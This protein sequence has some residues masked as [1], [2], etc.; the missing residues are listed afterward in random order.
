MKNEDVILFFCIGVVVVCVLSVFVFAGFQKE[1][2]QDVVKVFTYVWAFSFIV[3][4]FLPFAVLHINEHTK[5]K[6]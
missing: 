3:G 1:I 5:E 2:S 4:C 6:R